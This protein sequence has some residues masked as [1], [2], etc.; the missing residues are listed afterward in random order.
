MFSYFTISFSPGTLNLCHLLILERSSH[1]VMKTSHSCHE[2]DV[3][4]ASVRTNDFDTAKRASCIHCQGDS[5]F[6]STRRNDHIMNPHR[7]FRWFSREA[8]EC[9]RAGDKKRETLLSTVTASTTAALKTWIV[10]DISTSGCVAGSSTQLTVYAI[11]PQT[12]Q[13]QK[14]LLRRAQRQSQPRFKSQPQPQSQHL[15]IR[16][17]KIEPQAQPQTES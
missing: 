15:I 11:Q 10:A 1:Y 17:T 9:K 3:S 8:R 13:C 12:S 7:E 6:I 16:K 2:F 4:K 5:M 14:K